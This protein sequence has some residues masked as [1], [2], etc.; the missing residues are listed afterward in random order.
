[1]SEPKAEKRPP[2]GGAGGA[3]PD[4]ELAAADE[5]AASAHPDDARTTGFQ[6]PSIAAGGVSAFVFRIIELVATTLMVIV[7]GRL[8]EP[9]GRGLYALASLTISLLLLPLGA[10]WVGNAVE[11]ARRRLP[12]RELFG[13]SLVIAGVGGVATGLVALA[14][15][16]LLGDRWWVVAFPAAVTPFVLLLKYEE[17]FYTGLGHVRAV[18]WVRVARAVLPLVFITPPLL[19]GASPRTAIAI[20]TVSFVVLPVLILV[21]LR[22]LVGGPRLPG[23]RPYYRRVVTYGGKISGL[24]AVDTVNDRIGLIALAVFATEAAVGIFSIAIA[25]VQVLLVAPQA[26]ALSAF[27]RIGISSREPSAALTVRAMRH[28]ILLTSVGSLAAFPVVLVG[29]PWAVGDEYSDVPLLFALLIPNALFL[30]SLT[31]LYTYFQ[32]QARKPAT[33]LVVGGCALGA[34]LAL[35]IALAPLWGTWGVAIAASCAGAIG[36]GVAFQAFRK[37]SGTRLRELIPGRREVE[38]YLALARGWLRRR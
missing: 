29:V 32:V 28:S 6:P 36:G 7:T 27:R 30:A 25:A 31:S 37:E 1:M 13:G 3:A 34:N 24:N 14:V 5:R 19:A 20:W 15:A 38:D 35:S 18:N 8:M 17:G 4:H 33:L 2:P 10:V 23:D 22:L 9:A 21:P 12:L 16:P 26:L 11:M